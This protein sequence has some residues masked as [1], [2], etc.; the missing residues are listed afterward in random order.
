MIIPI[1]GLEMANQSGIA[2]RRG[3]TSCLCTRE[4]AFAAGKN[5]TRLFPELPDSS[6]NPSKELIDFMHS[7]MSD[8]QTPAIARLQDFVIPR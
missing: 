6:D 7:S 5:V 2:S 8:N 4:F 3:S 1:N